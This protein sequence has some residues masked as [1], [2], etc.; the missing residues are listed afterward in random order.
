MIVQTREWA[1]GLTL[2][3][4]PFKTAKML[5]NMAY[6]EA[7]ED[8]KNTSEYGLLNCKTLEDFKKI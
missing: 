1:I 8:F 5:K 7:F 3:V 6:S 2:F 4:R